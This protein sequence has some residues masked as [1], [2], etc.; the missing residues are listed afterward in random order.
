MIFVSVSLTQRSRDLETVCIYKFPCEN[1]VPFHIVN[2]LVFDM[3]CVYSL[4]TSWHLAFILYR[5]HYQA[6]VVAQNPG[7]ANPEISKVIGEQWRDSPL[8]VKKHWKSLA[9]VCSC[10]VP[11][12]KLIVDLLTSHRKKNSAIRNSIPITVTSLAELDEA[13]VSQVIKQERPPMSYHGAAN[14]A[15]AQSRHRQASPQPQRARRKEHQT[16]H[17]HLPGPLQVRMCHAT[18]VLLAALGL[19]A[20]QVSRTATPNS[21]HT[22]LQPTVSPLRT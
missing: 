16:H 4:L 18:F 10:T 3:V 14:A 15:A 11:K 2:F 9:D 13:T 1:F 7:L 12:Y 19:M 17:I 8:E 22:Q 5:Q 6:A 20:L 21:G